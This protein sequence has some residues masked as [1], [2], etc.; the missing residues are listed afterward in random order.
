[1]D[2]RIGMGKDKRNGDKKG[3]NGPLKYFYGVG[4]FG[5]S[6]MTNVETYFFNVFLTNLAQFLLGTVVLV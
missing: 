2:W 5:F 3:L 4:D 6:L 1:M